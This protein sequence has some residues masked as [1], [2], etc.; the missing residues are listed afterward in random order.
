M[1]GCISVCTIIYVSCEILLWKVFYSLFCRYIL[2]VFYILHCPQLQQQRSWSSQLHYRGLTMLRS[3]RCLHRRHLYYKAIPRE[4]KQAK[5]TLVHHN[6][7]RCW[8]I[9]KILSPADAAAMKRSLKI[10]PLLKVLATRTTL[11]HLIAF[12]NWSN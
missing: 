1:T 2:K 7:A 3:Y 4:Q 8:P 9:L 11:W 12:K 6:F 5:C 10:P